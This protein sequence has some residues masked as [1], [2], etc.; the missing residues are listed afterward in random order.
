VNRPSRARDDLGIAVK[1]AP[2]QSPRQ[3]SRDRAFPG[4]HKAGQNKFGRHF[5]KQE[6][7]REERGPRK[8]AALLFLLLLSPLTPLPSFQ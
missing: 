4:R 8:I 5:L 1:Q 2:S 6:R 7:L 3:G